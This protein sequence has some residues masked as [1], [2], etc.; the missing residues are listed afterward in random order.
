M[1]LYGKIIMG[2][3]MCLLLVATGCTP[4]PSAIQPS[5]ISSTQYSDWSCQKLNK[6]K[7]AVD[8]ALTESEDKQSKAVGS[9][10]VMTIMFGIIGFGTSKMMHGDNVDN[11][12]NLKGKSKAI[13]S[14]LVASGC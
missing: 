6:E 7:L 3:A 8:A 2:V 10:V 9:E 5:Y 14:Q 4:I 12:A 1:R 11:I 13:Q